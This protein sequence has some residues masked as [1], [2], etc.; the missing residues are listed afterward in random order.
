MLRITVTDFPDEQRWCLEGRL[1]GPW[2]AELRSIWRQT[3]RESD[4]RRCIVELND[5]TFIDENGEVA[6][7]EIM[8]QGAELIASGVYMKQWL[9]NLR[10]K[11]KRSG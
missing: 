11:S 9:G 6:L 3:R 7:R 8:C 1:V 2:V 10:S 5:V 4:M